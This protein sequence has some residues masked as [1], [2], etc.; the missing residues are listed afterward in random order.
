[1]RDTDKKR[2]EELLEENMVLEIAQKQSMNESVHL[3]WELE[4]L[5]KSTDLADSEKSFV[6]ELN[7]CASSR[8]LKLE[9]DNQSLQNTIQELR[10]A[11]LTSRES[12][13]KFVELEKENQQLSKKIEKLQNQIEKEKQ[14]NQDLETL[15]EELIKDKEQLQVAMETLK[16]DKDRQIKDLKQENDHL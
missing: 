9:K 5:S 7:E 4:Q 3:G 11:S 13:L 16:A 1:D 10:D 14:S 12:S 8:I 2:I 15:S 6:F